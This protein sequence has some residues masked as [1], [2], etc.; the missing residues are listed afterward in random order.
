M[1]ISLS[2]MSHIPE[3]DDDQTFETDVPNSLATSRSRVRYVRLWSACE[4]SFLL[5]KEDYLTGIQAG[6]C[7][8]E[9][10][11][12]V[13]A[14]LRVQLRTRCAAPDHL[15]VLILSTVSQDMIPYSGVLYGSR[16]PRAF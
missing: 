5:R 8:I 15:S 7:M 9:C 16:R 11:A 4:H 13:P 3:S 14:A 1:T 6:M 12:S 10:S 2:V